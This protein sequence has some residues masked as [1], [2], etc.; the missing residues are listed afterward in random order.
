MSNWRLNRIPVSRRVFL[1]AMGSAVVAGAWGNGIA[2][3]AEE[4]VAAPKLEVEDF[5]FASQFDGTEPLYATAVY[6]RGQ[7]GLPVML[8]QHGYDGNRTMLHYSATRMAQR[9]YFCLCVQTRGWG[10]QFKKH[11]QRGETQRSAGRHDA[12]GIETMDVYDGLQAAIDAFGERIDPARVSIAGYSYGGGMVYLCTVRYPY[13]FRAALACFGIPCY[14]RHVE[15][16]EQQIGRE[17][18]RLCTAIGARPEERPDLYLARSAILAAGNLSGTRFHIAHDEEETLCPLPNVYAFVEAARAHGY[19]HLF[20]HESRSTDAHRWRHMYNTN[21]NPVRSKN[22][23]LSPLEDAFLDDIASSQSAAPVMPAEGE[24]V[25]I[26]HLI[27]PRFRCV[28]GRG[29]DGAAR[30]RFS[31]G[32]GEVRFSFVPLTSDPA[33]PVQLT[34][35]DGKPQGPLWYTVDG[36]EPQPIVAGSSPTIVCRLDSVVRVYAEPAKG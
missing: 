6:P 31:F 34:L 30:V 22:D 14:R 25:V 36:G 28:A 3:G 16:R 17:A 12:G 15:L 26:G 29:D 32:Q 23:V 7:P 35:T 5:T 8:L 21:D 19:R 1:G 24:L 13:R 20:V 9:G 11:G 10:G 27:T 2:A 18:V 4:P 33:L